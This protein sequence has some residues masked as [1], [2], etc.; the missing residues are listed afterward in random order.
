MRFYAISDKD[1]QYYL[2]RKD[3]LI[4]DLR[5]PEDYMSGHL[6]GAVNIPEDRLKAKPGLLDGASFRIIIFCCERGNA[7]LRMA[8]N[9]SQRGYRAFSLT[10]GILSYRG[11]LV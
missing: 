5:K 11:E 8:A 4:V 2:K 10:G 6:P 7:S 1:L 9:F 3:V